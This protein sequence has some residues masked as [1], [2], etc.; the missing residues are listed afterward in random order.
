MSNLS[1]IAQRRRRSGLVNVRIGALAV[2]LCLVFVTAC[3]SDSAK[4]DG[5]TGVVVGK[6][7]ESVFALRVGDCL[8]GEVAEE[9]L[10]VPLVP[11]TNE[12]THEVFFTADV[13][14]D[15]YPGSA[16][17]SEFA[18]QQCVGHYYDYVGV[19]LSE[20]SFFFTYLFP[21][22]STWTSGKDR[23]VVCFVVSRLGPVLGTAKGSKL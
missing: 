6:G 22:V 13:P 7:S 5:T 8:I 14:G 19:E 18:E 9:V 20:S 21:S 2:S 1:H 16:A 4:R 23:Q 11:C 17:I 3:S 15:A 10:K 12:H